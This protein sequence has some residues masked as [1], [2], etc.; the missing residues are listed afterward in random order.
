MNQPQ[1]GASSADQ[2]GICQLASKAPVTKDFPHQ[3]LSFQDRNRIHEDYIAAT[4]LFR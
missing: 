4:N 3:V 2:P 1:K